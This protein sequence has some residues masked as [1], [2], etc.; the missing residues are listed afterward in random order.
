MIRGLQPGIGILEG[1]GLNTFTDDQLDEIH[2]ATLDVLQN[3]GVGV[4]SDEALDIFEGGG[5]IVDRGSSHVK[6][7]PYL[8]EDAI[9]SA[10]STILLA[11]RV[12]EYDVTIQGGRIGFVNFGTGVRVI[13]PFTGAFR[14]STLED[15][16]KAA[17][18]C[19]AMNHIDIFINAV[20]AGD[21]PESMAK[22]LIEAEVMFNNTAKHTIHGDFFSGV[23]GV[24][25]FFQMA[26]AI[27]GGVEKLRERPIVTVGGCPTSPLELGNEFCYIMI[28]GAKVGIP[29]LV[30]SMAMSGATAPISLAGTL[31]TQN[32]EVLSSLVMQQLVNKGG[33]FIYGSSTTMMDMTYGTAPV[34][35]PELGMISAGA[36]ALARHY[37][38]PCFMAGG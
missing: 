29:L 31:V 7:P 19:D 10:P 6:I 21:V 37:K 9:R 33:P 16:A 11:G 15:L 23:E 13:D 36:T 14:D 38:L 2:M 26:G 8:V 1:W 27:V 35:A 3:Y 17:L 32:A 5:A 12:P 4:Y 25:K 34:G 30:I 18:A 20:D 22:G 24:R 28:E